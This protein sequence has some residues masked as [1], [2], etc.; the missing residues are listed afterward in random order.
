MI[1]WIVDRVWAWKNADALAEIDQHIA[2]NDAT[3]ARLEVKMAEMYG[4]DWRAEAERRLAD[5]MSGIYT[6]V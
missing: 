6:T 2:F 5:R 4:P 1:G 3:A